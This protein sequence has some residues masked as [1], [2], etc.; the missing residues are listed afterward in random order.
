MTATSA[1]ISTTKTMTVIL[2][3]MKSDLAFVRNSIAKKMIGFQVE[4]TFM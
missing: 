4:M 1:T 3:S 2:N